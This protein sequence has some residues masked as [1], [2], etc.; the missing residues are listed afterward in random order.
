MKINNSIFV[1]DG[2]DLDLVCGGGID[3][4]RGTK[5][6]RERDFDLE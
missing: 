3:D 4:A 2:S 5:R 6:E 1:Y